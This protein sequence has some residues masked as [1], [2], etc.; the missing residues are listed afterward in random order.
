MAETTARDES[1][2]NLAEL[3]AA[4]RFHEL[5]QRL[6]AFDPPDLADIIIA[7]A[8]DDEAIVFRLLPK[9]L[10]TLTFEHLPFDA[11]EGL[12]KGLG[13]HDVASILDDMSPDDRTALL[14][15]LPGKVT[16]RMLNL[17]S[18]EERKV[19]TQLLGYPEES[20]GRL[21]TPDWV[22]VKPQWKVREALEHIRHFGRDSETLNVVYVV[23]K[24]GTLVDDLRM[25]ELLLIDPEAHIE[26]LMD[27]QFVALKASDDQEE[28]VAVFRR[29]DRTALPVVDSEGIL[30][31]IVT[32]DDVLDVAEA[33]A[34]EDFHK[35]GAS[36]AL[37]EPYLT[38]RLGKMIRKRS[39]WLILL[40]FGQMLTTS[41]MG[42]FAE[43]IDQALVLTLF[44]P[45]I[46]SSGGNSGSQAATLTI[47]ALAVGEARLEDWWR[48]ARRELG[49]GLAIG[50]VMGGL[51]FLRV[52]IGEWSGEDYGGAWPY[53]GLTI[54]LSLLGVV[55]WGTLMGG[56]LPLFLKRMGVDP[57]T[58][59]TPFVATLVDVTGIVLY[60]SIAT[61]VLR[62]V[63]L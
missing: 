22:A 60:F 9:R 20:I 47:R 51:G 41:A 15:E 13:D 37:D 59:S 34:T 5:R 7:L 53:V 2:A 35:L 1:L 46:I 10:A 40:F 63:L 30:V 28:A 11:Q 42:H 8:S 56:L 44:L 12:L 36:A 39:V 18:P 61:V 38:I 54:W 17:L 58:S 23:A 55:M 27:S 4:R 45:L 14:E 33:E 6:V 32:V 62:G 19:A 48:V 3:I 26:D 29:F 21:M 50:V 25:R 57:A 43:E 31:G 49:S 24:G 16:K 52:A